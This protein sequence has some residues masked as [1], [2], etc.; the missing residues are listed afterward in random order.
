MKT[1]QVITT[2]TVAKLN[3]IWSSKKIRF[4]RKLSAPPP[5]FTAVRVGA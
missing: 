4:S 1:R 3:N 5:S 2:A